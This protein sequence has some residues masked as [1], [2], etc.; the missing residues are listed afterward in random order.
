MLKKYTE[1]K[2]I[3]VLQ[4]RISR[5]R[6]VRRLPPWWSPFI[7]YNYVSVVQSRSTGKILICTHSWQCPDDQFCDPIGD[8]CSSC[9]VDVCN[10]EE[11]DWES[12]ELPVFLSQWVICMDLC[13]LLGL[14]VCCVVLAFIFA[15]LSDCIVLV[16]V[17]M[18][19]WDVEDNKR[20]RDDDSSRRGQNYWD[21]QQYRK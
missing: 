9:E 7:S 19:L 13:L 18:I 16:C 10:E 1:L 20:R 4:Q 21:L 14:F 3:L 15:F 12:W 11:R 6:W 17:D 2:L 8:L 5:E